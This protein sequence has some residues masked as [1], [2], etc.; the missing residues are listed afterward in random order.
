MIN[1]GQLSTTT[2]E[3]LPD[4]TDLTINGEYI[5]VSP[6][7]E[8]VGSLSGNGPIRFVLSPGSHLCVGFNDRDSTFDGGIV[9]QSGGDGQL[10]KIGTGT[11]T[12]TGNNSYGEGTTVSGGTLVLGH[13][14]A[15]GT[16][17][18]TITGSTLGYGNGVNIVNT[19]DL[20]NNATL[21][22]TT[23]AATQSGAIGETS[24]PWGITKTGTGTLT[25]SGTNTY[26]GGTTIGDG[27]L[28]ISNIVNLGGGSSS[29][30][31]EGGTLHTDA[32]LGNVLLGGHPFITTAS[33]DARF[34]VDSVPARFVS[35]GPVS[36][37]GGL[38]KTGS[39]N[40]VQQPESFGTPPP[41]EFSL[42]CRL[43]RIIKCI[44]ISGLLH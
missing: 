3:V 9:A 37:V 29:V 21:D 17:G 1:Q 23:G 11:L 2:S 40:L 6:V 7:T 10:T 30:I 15:A 5:F 41:F 39:G 31:F 24:G 18:I 36:G 14:S 27:V 44:R 19:I 42:F 28:S 4:G 32:T 33:G 20:Q 22:V 35:L 43:F 16:G 34:D 25:L 26:S 38:I 12:L 13:S 8:T